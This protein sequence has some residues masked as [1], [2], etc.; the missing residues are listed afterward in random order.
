MYYSLSYY[1][2]QEIEKNFFLLWKKTQCLVDV[3]FK[4]LRLRIFY[5]KDIWFVHKTQRQC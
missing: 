5:V 3:I 1:I 4:S 2:K